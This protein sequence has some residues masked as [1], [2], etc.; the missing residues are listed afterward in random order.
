VDTRSSVGINLIPSSDRKES[1]R[2]SPEGS[3]ASNVS[4]DGA[5]DG[6]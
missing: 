2:L 5:H 6:N 4:D 3:H 1:I